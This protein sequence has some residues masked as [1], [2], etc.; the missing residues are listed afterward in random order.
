MC[1]IKKKIV[2]FKLIFHLALAL[3]PSLPVEIFPNTCHVPVAHLSVFKLN[4]HSSY[5]VISLT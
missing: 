5:V 1:P 2:V 4:Y 3:Y